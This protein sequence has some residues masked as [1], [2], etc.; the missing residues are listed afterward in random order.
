MRWIFILLLLV[1]ALYFGWQ[2]RESTPGAV[3]VLPANITHIRLLD[4]VERTLLLPRSAKTQQ[5]SVVNAPAA[6]SSVDQNAIGGNAPKEI[7]TE[8]LESWCQVLSGFT[9][10][11]VAHELLERLKRLGVTSFVLPVEVERVLAYELALDRPESAA[12]QQAMMDNLAALELSVEEARVNSKTVYIIG[13]YGS[14]RAM[15]Q[16]YDA[17]I[18]LFEPVLYQVVSQD[19]Q[20]ELWVE[21]DASVKNNNKINDLDGFLSSEIKIE[22]K[23]CK[24]VAS[25]G[26]RD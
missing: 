18:G 19:S 16:A 10:V 17:L 1:N 5:S 22:K 4:E 6:A 20:F 7:A 9:D 13:R 24:G 15:N 3:E 11:A 8:S 25:V 14:H 26:A 12:G 23:L 2:M 21:S